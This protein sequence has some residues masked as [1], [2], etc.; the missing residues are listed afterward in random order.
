MTTRVHRSV[1]LATSLLCSAV[2]LFGCQGRPASQMPEMPSDAPP[3][4]ETLA[5]GKVLSTPDDHSLTAAEYLKLGMPATDRAWGGEEMRR[6][7]TTLAAMAKDDAGRLPRYR[8]E[9]SG[10]LFARMTSSQN[11]EIYHNK[12]LSLDLRMSPALAYFGATNDILQVYVG[13]FLKGATGDSELMELIGS[14]LRTAVVLLQLVDEELPTIKQGDPNAA[15]QLAGLEKMRN[16]LATMTAGALTT[17]TEA[18]SYRTSERT[19]LLRYLQETLP[20]IVTHVSPAAQSETQVR[21][22][23]L[24]RDQNLKPLQPG[25]AELASAVRGVVKQ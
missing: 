9:R 3:T 2:V 16:G 12:K 18:S 4:P 11:L 5:N 1:L 25:L 17:L 10:V 14:E 6:A 20:A 7:A 8:S 23:A 15:G 13:S 24:A 21:I 19:R 22:E